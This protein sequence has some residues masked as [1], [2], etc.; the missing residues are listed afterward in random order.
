MSN[1]FSYGLDDELVPGPVDFALFG[2]VVMTPSNADVAGEPVISRA[3]VP[4]SGTAVYRKQESASGVVYGVR[5][6]RLDCVVK[7]IPDFSIE[8]EDEDDRDTNWI[9]QLDAIAAALDY[10]TGQPLTIDCYPGE[11][12]NAV[13]SGPVSMVSERRRRASMTVEFIEASNTV[14]PI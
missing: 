8:A 5:H 7:A 4:G 14:A 13:V 11:T 10:M 6:I 2:V 12:W 1:S 3:E 9:A